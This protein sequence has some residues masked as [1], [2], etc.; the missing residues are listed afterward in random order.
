MGKLLVALLIAGC[1]SGG[2]ADGGA[3]AGAVGSCDVSSG[4]AHTCSDYGA[5]SP[6]QLPGLK[7]ACSGGATWSDSACDRTGAVGGCQEKVGGADA[8]V[9]YYASPGIT[10]ATV[11]MACS[12]AG[13][14]FIAGEASDGGGGGCAQGGGKCA[15]FSDCCS[16][17]CANQVCT[18]CQAQGMSCTGSGAGKC[19]TGLTC[20]GSSCIVQCGSG[21]DLCNAPGDCC[22][23]T[24]A[25]GQCTAPPNGCSGLVKCML[26][27]PSSDSSCTG[28]CC[29]ACIAGSTAQALTLLYSVKDCI[30]EYLLYAASDV[31]LC[32][33]DPTPSYCMQCAPQISAC[34]SDLP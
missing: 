24:C 31:Y 9:W 20:M 34:T 14:T 32:T 23:K 25:N 13:G 29:K 30:S 26:T 2:A 16:G 5:I 7:Q 3:G 10:A 4:A 33:R 8:T 28:S 15:V 21:G 18:S 12:A 27:C 17:T 6:A 22:S 11:M 19:C 1:S